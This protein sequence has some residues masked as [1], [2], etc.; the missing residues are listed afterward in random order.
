M[1]AAQR[2]HSGSTHRGCHLRLVVLRAWRCCYFMGVLLAG[3]ELSGGSAGDE[4]VHGA[5]G[6]VGAECRETFFHIVAQN[7]K[8]SYMFDTT[9]QYRVRTGNFLIYRDTVSCIYKYLQQPESPST[10]RTR[11]V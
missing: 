8:Y 4:M 2:W 10:T 3:L 1:V 11:V 7:S 5:I 9:I 6:D